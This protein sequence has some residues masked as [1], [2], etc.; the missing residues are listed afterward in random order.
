MDEKIVIFNRKLDPES[1]LNTHAENTIPKQKT[2]EEYIHLYH[3][4]LPF[5]KMP[6]F[7][8]SKKSHH[9]PPQCCKACLIVWLLTLVSGWP[10][11]RLTIRLILLIS[12]PLLLHRHRNDHVPW[13]PG[14]HGRF[15]GLGGRC[16]FLLRKLLRG[17]KDFSTTKWERCVFQFM[18]QYS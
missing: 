15:N 8:P 9:N 7:I 4:H 18:F 5:R 12:P 14:E 13:W 3:C 6:N 1:S 11:A 17:W 10:G 16:P 2:S